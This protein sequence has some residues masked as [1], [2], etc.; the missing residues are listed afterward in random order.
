MKVIEKHNFHL[1]RYRKFTCEG[2]REINKIEKIRLTELKN[3][4]QGKKQQLME[5]D[6]D[7]ITRLIRFI[8]DR[9]KLVAE[10]FDIRNRK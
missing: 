2:R 1:N 9:T 8:H 6:L 5:I 7:N 4:H 10:K 3:M